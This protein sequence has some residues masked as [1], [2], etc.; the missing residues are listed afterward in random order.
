MALLAN[1]VAGLALGAFAARGSSVGNVWT[2]HMVLFCLCGCVVCYDLVEWAIGKARGDSEA[3]PPKWPLKLVL[4]VDFLFV[5]WFALLYVRELRSLGHPYRCYSVLAVYATV[6]P[7]VAM[8]LHG[9]CFCKE[10][11]ALKKKGAFR[12]PKGWRR[13]GGYIRID[14]ENAPDTVESNRVSV[15]D[16]VGEARLWSMGNSYLHP[17]RN[18]MLLGL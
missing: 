1:T 3:P 11:Q 6:P 15:H 16:E 14:G 7:L 12:F 18:R 5:V 10:I 9:T 17:S 4:I 2:W 8:V 13:R